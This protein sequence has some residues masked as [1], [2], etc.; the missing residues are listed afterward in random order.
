MEDTTGAGPDIETDSTYIE[1]I[2]LNNKAA[3]AESIL[4]DFSSHKVYLCVSADV[5][6]TGTLKSPVYDINN[7]RVYTE[8]SNAHFSG[9]A[10][11]TPAQQGA[12]LD[13]KGRLSYRS[14]STNV[15]EHYYIVIIPKV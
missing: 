6:I 8:P 3:I 15:D 10:E 1:D 7:Q 5:K 14:M 9:Y 11:L 4:Y 2:P 12:I 13:A